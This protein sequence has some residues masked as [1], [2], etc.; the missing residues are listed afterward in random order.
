MCVILPFARQRFTP[1]DMAAWNAILADRRRRGLWQKVDRATSRDRDW[2]MV[3]LPGLK[4]PSL[5]LERDSK[6]VY[7][8]S[9]Y[10]GQGWFQ[11][12]QGATII[13]CLSQIEPEA[14]LKAAARR[15]D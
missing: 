7:G 3:W 4:E 15:A 10:D 9:Y 13:D 11:F 14:Q 1:S 8:L 6:G 12:R 5:R 2:I